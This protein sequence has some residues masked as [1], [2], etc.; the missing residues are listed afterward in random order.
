MTASELAFFKPPSSAPDRAFMV[1]PSVAPNVAPELFHFQ[2]L[3]TEV[4]SAFTF[5]R[6]EEQW[7]TMI[8]IKASLLGINGRLQGFTTVGGLN[9]DWI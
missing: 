5:S 8:E 7:R 6:G 2:A 1:A 4:A 9:L 3:V